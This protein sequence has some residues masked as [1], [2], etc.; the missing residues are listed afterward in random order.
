MRLARVLLLPLFVVMALAGAWHLWGH[1]V[2]PLLL[3]GATLAV[4]AFTALP[5]HA[6]PTGA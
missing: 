4:M 6:R 2:L 5:R 3:A 1:R